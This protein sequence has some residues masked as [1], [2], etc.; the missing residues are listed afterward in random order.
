MSKKNRRQEKSKTPIISKNLETDNKFSES[1]LWTK[2]R[3][4]YLGMGADAWKSGAVPCFITSNAFIGFVYAKQIFAYMMDHI[5]LNP[6]HNAKEPFYIV[7]TGAGHGKLSF[8]IVKALNEI[9]AKNKTDNNIFKYVMTDIAKRNADYWLEHHAFQ[10]YFSNET[11]D[12][13]VFDADNED[14]IALLKSGA[15]LSP[16]SL[17]KP[18]CMVGNYII[19]TLPHDAFDVIDNKAHASLITTDLEH[20]ENKEITDA[21]ILNYMKHE[22]HSK[23]IEGEFYNDKILNEIISEYASEF[24]EASFLIPIGGIKCIKAL[25]ALSS[26]D[27]ILI[28]AD[29]GVADTKTFEGIEEPFI[30]ASDY[31]A[32]MVNFDSIKRYF[33]KQGGFFLQMPEKSSSFQVVTASSGSLKNYHNLELTY[34]EYVEGFGPNDFFNLEDNLFKSNK[35]PSLELI[36]S[37]L[38]ISRYDPHVFYKLRD[39]LIDQLLEDEADQ[40]FIDDVIAELPKVWENFFHLEEEDLP[41]EM[42]RLLYSQDKSKE[43]IKYYE[44]SLEYFGRESAVIFNLGLCYQD[45]GEL[46]TALKYFGEVLNNDPNFDDVKS[47]YKK[48][49][50]KINDNHKTNQQTSLKEAEQEPA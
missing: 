12:C 2:L 28:S 37:L 3:D 18:I 42:A 39:H 9:L 31:A 11:L 16:N 35:S 17:T 4:Y 8:Y 26:G 6:N 20:P 27:F 40:D 44:K 5:K 48:V 29:K 45:I 13:A 23:P 25:K 49:E 1:I 19:D 46:D 30:E 41:F 7:E 24:E 50:K 33:N 38:R 34:N 15:V 32:L 47:W 43:A 22:F 36:M 10:K 21:N 14:S